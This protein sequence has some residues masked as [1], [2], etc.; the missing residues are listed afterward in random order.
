LLFKP[1]QTVAK[2]HVQAVGEEGDEEVRLDAVIMLVIDR[3]DGKIALERLERLVDGNQPRTSARRTLLHRIAAQRTKV[4]QAPILTF[5]PL[6]NKMC[7]QVDGMLEATG[8]RCSQRR[9]QTSRS[10]PRGGAASMPSSSLDEIV[11]MPIVVNPAGRE[12]GW[13]KS[14]VLQLQELGRWLEGRFVVEP[15]ARDQMIQA[16][17]YLDPDF[18]RAAIEAVKTTHLAGNYRAPE[19]FDTADDDH[20]IDVRIAASRFTRQYC[21]SISIAALTALACGVGL[22]LSIRR[23]RMVLRNNMP[24]F[25]HL[26]VDESAILRCRE[27]PTQWPICEGPV[28]DSLAELRAHVW[29]KLY[30]ENVVP[31]FERVHQLTKI[32]PRLLWSNCAEWPAMV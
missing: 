31:L 18:L 13:R 16:E 22:D 25:V 21:S 3:P 4:R 32:A 29:R 2:C 6:N 1:L 28:V 8:R 15:T 7:R 5:R 20:D 19:G 11:T 12:T 17:N 26:D 23:C 30:A 14:L 27:R 24:F 10:T 9:D